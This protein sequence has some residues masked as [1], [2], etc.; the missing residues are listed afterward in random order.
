MHFRLPKPLHGWREFAGEVG[1]IVVGVLIALGAEQVVEAAHWRREVRTFRESVDR[2]IG[3]DLGTDE[4]RM[5]ENGCVERRLDEL[6]AWLQSWREGRP[7]K[8]TGPIGIPASLSPNT[9]VWGSRSA[10]IVSHMPP[11]ITF[12]YADLYDEFSNN[13]VHRLDERS[14]WLELADFD[15]ATQLDHRDLMRLQ[16]LITRARLRDQ[17]I[18]LNALNYYKKAARMGIKP[19]KDPTWAAPETAICRPILSPV[20]HH[21]GRI[22]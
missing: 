18:T 2:E 22:G 3:I 16:G 5:S 9:S 21:A 8:L 19:R 7:V 17:R 15:G 6:Q 13:D 14:A 20:Q 10:E 11:R 4:Y 12:A 1:I